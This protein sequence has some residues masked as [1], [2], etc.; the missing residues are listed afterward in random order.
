MSTTD[1]SRPAAGRFYRKE[2][3]ALLDHC[4]RVPLTLLLA[5]A[6]AGKST[7]LSQWQTGA[8]P[9]AVV[10]LNLRPV[11]DD[12]VRFLRR[13]AEQT[14]AVVPAFD[15]SWFMPFD[16]AELPPSS[17]ADALFD[18][19]E[20][21]S[22]PLFIVFDDFQHIRS[23]ETLSV[24]STL[25]DQPPADVHLI[26]ASRTQP[27]FDVSRLRLDD[28]VVEIG[29]ADLKIRREEVTALNEGLGGTALDEDEL[30]H[31]LTIT[32][33]WMAGVKIALLA[34]MRSGMQTLQDFDASQPELM[35]YFGHAVLKGL[36]DTAR[37]LF[38]QSSL[39]DS[40]NAE[41]CDQVLHS[42]RAARLIEELTSRELFLIPVPGKSG[43]YRYHALLKDFLR[44]RVAIDMPDCIAPIHRRATRYFV[45][46]QNFR[47]AVWPVSYTHLTLPTKRIV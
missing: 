30:A 11:D 26:I 34:A 8:E 21:V 22:E 33:G 35:E 13:F 36:P 38:M 4:A 20:Q 6:G 5:P 12:P 40:F 10:S 39:L 31:L 47:Q 2:L 42:D 24:I 45:R 23:P 17:I 28:A 37:T 19:L 46:Q 18:A 9:R 15:T 27:S 14:R 3:V 25:L 1:A 29:A 32:E 43:W 16:V 7:L 44:A 41:L